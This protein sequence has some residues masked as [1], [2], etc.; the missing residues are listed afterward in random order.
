[1]FFSLI[2]SLVYDSDDFGYLPECNHWHCKSDSISLVLNSECLC[3]LLQV[4]GVLQSGN[5]L[6]ASQSV[7]SRHHAADSKSG[8]CHLDCTATL[9]FC[10]HLD[11]GFLSICP[12]QAAASLPPL[13]RDYTGSYSPSEKRV[14]HSFA[15]YLPI[16]FVS[17][18]SHLSTTYWPGGWVVLFCRPYPLPSLLSLSN[19]PACVKP[20]LGSCTCSTHFYKSIL[21]LPKTSPVWDLLNSGLWHVSLSVTSTSTTSCVAQN[22]SP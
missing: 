2:Y 10:V 11:L 12:A 7:L 18:R 16:L 20:L 1:M 15:A 9:P 14:S 3:Q 13:L 4:M 17:S 8:A 19:L 22:V 5:C 21:F 6:C